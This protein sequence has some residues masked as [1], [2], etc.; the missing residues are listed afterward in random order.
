[1]IVLG[2]NADIDEQ[3]RH[4]HRFLFLIVDR[5]E[6]QHGR[7]RQ[8]ILQRHR[9]GGVVDVGILFNQVAQPQHTAALQVALDLGAVLFPGDEILEHEDKLVQPERGD[10][11]VGGGTVIPPT[12]L[13]IRLLNRGLKDGVQ[14]GRHR[15]CRLE[16]AGKAGHKL[17]DGDPLGRNERIDDKGT[18]PVVAGGEDLQIRDGVD[19]RPIL[20]F[21]RLDRKKGNPLL[22]ELQQKIDRKGGLSGTGFADHQHV[23][24]QILGRAADRRDAPRQY[25]ELKVLPRNHPRV[26]LLGILQRSVAGQSGELVAPPAAVG[27]RWSPPRRRAASAVETGPAAA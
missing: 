2:I 4:Q 20:G 24:G 9:V 15:E 1:M 18:D 22:V 19:H 17:L 6:F 11:R 26:E 12:I 7:V 5:V 14:R 13:D 25:P 27:K 21:G 16:C 10:V 23:L 8:Q 3:Q